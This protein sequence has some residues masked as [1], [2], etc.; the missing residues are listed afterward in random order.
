[1]LVYKTKENLF[2]QLNKNGSE[3]PEEKNLI[4]PVHQHARHDVTCKP[5]IGG[6]LLGKFPANDRG[7]L[8]GEKIVLIRKHNHP[9]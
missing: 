3:L 5:S 6:P 4:V 7:R 2:T 8:L 1:M 9:Q